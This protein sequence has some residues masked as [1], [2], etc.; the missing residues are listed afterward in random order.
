MYDSGKSQFSFHAN[1]GLIIN[2]D[3]H[4]VIK[5]LKKSG[6]EW[7]DVTTALYRVNQGEK[8]SVNNLKGFTYNLVDGKVEASKLT[9]ESIFE[10]KNTDNWTSHK[11]TMPNVKEGSIIEYSYRIQSPFLF[12]L[13]DWTFQRTIPTLWSEYKA[14]IPEY[15]DYKQVSQGYEP[16]ETYTANRVNVELGLTGNNPTGKEHHWIMKDV[17]ALQEEPYMTSINN[18]VS[19]I[20]FEL[21]QVSFPGQMITNFN[22]TWE[23]VSANLMA[24][25]RFGAQLTKTGFTKET[26]APLVANESDP[27]K[28]MQIIYAYIKENIKCNDHFRLFAENNLRKALETRTGSSADINL[29]LVAMLKEAGLE[30]NPVILSTRSN[31]FVGSF[32]YPSIS[33]FNY[34]I[35]HVIIGEKE[36]LL[37]ASE[38]DAMPNMLPVRC[39]NREGLLVSA[40]SSRWVSLM[41][42]T[43]ASNM[44]QS[45]FVI[46]KDNSVTGKIEH[47]SAGYAAMSYRKKITAEGEK[48]YV[49]KAL[50]KTDY[51]EINKFTIRNADAT[52]EAL[53]IGYEVNLA[54]QEKPVNTIYLKPMQNLGEKEN[55]FKLDTRKFPVDFATPIDETH[56]YSYTLPEGYKVEEQP[57]NAVISLPENGGR[58]IYSITVLGNTV[59]VM[60]KLTINRPSFQAAEY[61]NLKEFYNHIVAKHA[62]QIVI[63]QQS[64]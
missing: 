40:K 22:N 53:K 62:E 30:A 50:S 10:E 26:L 54:G 51:W 2:F 63:K 18:F 56:V 27:E 49:E 45:S 24:S 60:S 1:T 35:G 16:Y 42:T 39:L 47:S 44:Y 31:G 41:P 11:F 7:A 36:Y 12:T 17:P 43:K 20:E 13:R 59:N 37:D 58:F 33:K 52:S 21:G 32:T 64:N 29:L 48:K 5:I 14:I 38:R 46:G 19:R 3:R 57:K 9:K 15:F 6:Y 61:P 28:K 34:V 23:K 25:D 55:P 4:V 8:E